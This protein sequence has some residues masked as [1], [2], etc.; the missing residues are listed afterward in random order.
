MIKIFLISCFAYVFMKCA[1]YGLERL[2][3]AI[4]TDK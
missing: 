4:N 1:T 2:W 3:E